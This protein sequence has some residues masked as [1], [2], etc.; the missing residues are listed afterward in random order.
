MKNVEG[1]LFDEL[2]SIELRQPVRSMVDLASISRWRI[3]GSAAYVVRPTN[4]AE[5]VAVRRVLARHDIPQVVIGETSNL[6]FDSQG[7]DGVVIQISSSFS[8]FTIV[9]TRVM[10]QAGVTVPLLAR[11]AGEAGLTGIEHTVGIPGT[12][13]GL[14]T[15]N[16]GSQRKGI[17]S[18][19]A[20]VK[21]VMR[22]GDVIELSQVECGFRY[23]YS[24]LQDLDTAVTEVELELSKGD[25]A[26]AAAEMDRVLSDR[27]G[28]F[29]AE[30]PNCGSTFLSNPAMYQSLGTPGR[31]IEELGFK[32]QRRGGA[33]VSQLHANFINNVGGA[34]SEDV[35][36]LISDIRAAVYHA[37][38]Y[39]LD[40][41]ARHVAPDGAIRP[42][43]EVADE[44]R[45][46][47]RHLVSP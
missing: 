8:N 44:R 28:K 47:R 25:P 24:N 45:R 12:L 32:G 3:G 21:C 15:M 2:Q 9:G 41:E 23:R 13:G 34:T 35:L 26:A 27:H 39:R 18:H 33:Q 40:C 7:F 16:G 4:T 29:P 14:V 20:R 10:A 37:T 42:A 30:L 5:V 46:R 17:G 22:D 36:D 31:I 38:G 1:R 43:H 11:A 19:V 6:L